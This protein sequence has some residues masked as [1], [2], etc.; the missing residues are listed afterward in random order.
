M[1]VLWYIALFKKR[2]LVCLFKFEILRVFLI[3]E[4]FSHLRHVLMIK[5]LLK[6]GKMEL[7]KYQI[8]P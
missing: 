5:S 4:K 6:Y 1:K 7:N 2:K 3:T 8:R